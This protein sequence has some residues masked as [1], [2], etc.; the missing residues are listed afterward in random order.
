MRSKGLPK[1]IKREGKKRYTPHDQILFFEGGVQ[2]YV[3]NVVQIW[4]NKWTHLITEDGQEFVVNPD[5]VLYVQ[6]YI[7]Q[8]DES[9]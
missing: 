3:N 4:Q 2:R 7:K 8:P 6:R 9:N 5:K 1:I